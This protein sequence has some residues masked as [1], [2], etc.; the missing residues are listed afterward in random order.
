MSIYYLKTGSKLRTGNETPFTTEVIE[1]YN[2]DEA[3]NE[4]RKITKL[5]P[6]NQVEIV[7]CMGIVTYIETK[8]GEHEEV[9]F[10]K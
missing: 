5:N 8:A 7:K 3:L 9:L 10:N 2:L 1:F 4:A 6:N